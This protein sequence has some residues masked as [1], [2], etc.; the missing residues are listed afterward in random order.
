[1]IS[2]NTIASILEGLPEPYRSEAIQN[3]VANGRCFNL[4]YFSELV[5]H[6]HVICDA[7]L[8]AFVWERT[9]QGKEYWTKIYNK[10]KNGG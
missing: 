5:D 4:V 2:K 7:L 6:K 8:S 1:M 3:T 10:I 9:G